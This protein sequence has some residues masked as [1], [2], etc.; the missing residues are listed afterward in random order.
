[1]G[2]DAEQRCM[3]VARHDPE[4]WELHR[5][6]IWPLAM[7]GPDIP[8]NVAWVCPTLH[9]GQIHEIIALMMRRG[10]LTYTEINAAT[11]HRVNRYGYDLAVRG[12]DAV[13][14]G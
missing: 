9:L 3:C 13:W 6:H 1:M 7:G 11:E 5:H 4:P 14:R 12:Y 8:A 2:H 10:R